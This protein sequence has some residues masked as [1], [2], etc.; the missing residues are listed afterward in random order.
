MGRDLEGLSGARE[1]LERRQGVP[2]VERALEQA[3]LAGEPVPRRGLGQVLWDAD[4]LLE[5]D[6]QTVGRVLRSRL[7]GRAEQG[8]ARL[9]VAVAAFPNTQQSRKVA[10]RPGAPT[11]G[12]PA[13]PLRGRGRVPP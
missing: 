4:T 12:G 1:V 8:R 3:P 7:R 6:A 10:L 11:L 9:R 5:A 13:V 2:E